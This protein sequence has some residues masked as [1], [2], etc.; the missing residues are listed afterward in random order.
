MQT[1]IES[2]PKEEATASA[3]ASGLVLTPPVAG[4]GGTPTVV[5]LA[6]PPAPTTSHTENQ[7]V[8]VVEAAEHLT[9]PQQ[10]NATTVDKDLPPSGSHATTTTKEG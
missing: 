7:K 10:H 9:P 8:A 5:H 2:A 1:Q 4:F 6:P 3:P